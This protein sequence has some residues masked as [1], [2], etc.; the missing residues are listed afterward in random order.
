M[1]INKFFA[2]DDEDLKKSRINLGCKKNGE[3]LLNCL[4]FI[5]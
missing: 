4:I 5:T 1:K 3:H 2:F